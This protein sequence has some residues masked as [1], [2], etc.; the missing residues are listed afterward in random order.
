MALRNEHKK[1]YPS[2][3]Y[4][5]SYFRGD[6]R[7]DVYLPA[8]VRSFRLGSVRGYRAKSHGKRAYV[9]ILKLEE[10]PTWD[11][12]KECFVLDS[13]SKANLESLIREM[14]VCLKNKSRLRE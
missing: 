12:P 7:F 2:L 3:E 4:H 14:H 9:R 6:Y 11:H 5:A 10:F 8:N 1:G 13:G